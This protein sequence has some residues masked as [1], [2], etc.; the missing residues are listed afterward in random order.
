MK[1][2]F[3]PRLIPITIAIASATLLPIGVGASPT[4]QT[5]YYV[6]G[7]GM[8]SQSLSQ[9][10]EN[11]Q[12][13]AGVGGANFTILGSETKVAITITDVTGKRLAATYR[14]YDQPSGISVGPGPSLGSGTF[15]GTSGTLTIPPPTFANWPRG[16]SV[17]FQG[18]L[19]SGSACGGPTVGTT[20][21][22]Q[23]TFS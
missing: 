7:E 10:S 15:C 3:R 23:A 19:T 11:S 18:P 14:F 6:W 4:T 5:S 1:G 16:L 12:T 20:G 13:G 17:T 22:I 2:K 21:T 9:E 8:A